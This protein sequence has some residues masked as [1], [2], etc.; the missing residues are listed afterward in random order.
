MTAP[1]GAVFYYEYNYGARKGTKVP[2]Q[3]GISNY[4]YDQS[5]DGQ[6]NA[7]DNMIKNFGTFYSSE[8]VDY[9]VICTDGA[10]AA[11]LTN[12]S[13][14]CRIAGWLPIRT[15]GT[16]GQRTFSVIAYARIATGSADRV[17]TS[18]TSGNFK[19]QDGN[20]CGSISFTAGTWSLSAK[21]SGGGADTFKSSTVI[22]LQYTYQT[23]LA[24][25][26]GT[27]Q[28]PDVSLDIS[29]Q[30]VVAEGRKLRT[31]WSPEAA[32]D[33]KALHGLDAEAE[34]VAGISNEIALEIDRQI[35][36]EI[37]ANPGFSTTYTHVYNEATKP[38]TELDSIR[39]LL[40]KITA[41]SASIHK[42]SGRAPANWIVTSPMVVGLLSQLSTH[43]EFAGQLNAAGIA[44][45]VQLVTPPTY[46]PMMANTGIVNVGTILN[47]FQVFQD[48]YM[49]D[50]TILMGLRGASFLDAGF[51]FCPYI[52]LQM[53]PTFQDP[54][55]F[56]FKKGLRSRY[57]TKMLR[58]EYYGKI[59]V[60]GL[61]T[62]TSNL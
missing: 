21:V 30:T 41:M 22:Y 8:Y 28:V 60:S 49:D 12:A 11:S 25:S 14:N 32:D 17:L 45:N 40:T 58:P 23:E 20:A 19:D 43:R 6:L 61:P 39:G 26:A 34:L 57:A 15:P 59:T 18:D 53:T 35:L 9:D 1:V 36:Y 10:G 42:A 47:Q 55:D 2:V 46:G 50:S 31:N 56:K 3:K 52:A 4:P 38:N 16:S 27:A 7:G 13:A 48:P 51:A 54:V 29:M 44:N 24:T 5:Y 37:A 62:V 33:L